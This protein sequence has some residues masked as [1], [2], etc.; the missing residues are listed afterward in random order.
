MALSTSRSLWLALSLTLALATGAPPVAAQKAGA[1]ADAG[2]S[3]SPTPSPSPS[4][5]GAPASIDRLRTEHAAIKDALYR[6]RA[7][8]DTLEGALLATQILP[9][10]KWEGGGRYLLKQAELRLDGVR[11]W[12]ASASPPGDR[13][14]ALAARGLPPGVHVLGVRIEVRLRDNPKLGYLSEQSFTLTLP[15]GKKTTVEVT[16]DEDGSPPSYNPDIEVEIDD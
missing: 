16:I 6:S 15:E 10:L 3:P 2:A 5:K 12:D 8:R 4:P 14:V 11:I 13:P 1:G 7:R 9:V